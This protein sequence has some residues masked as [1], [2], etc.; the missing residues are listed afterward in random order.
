MR[1]DHRRTTLNSNRCP[2]SKELIMSKRIRKSFR[3]TVE[4]LETRLVPTQILVNTTQDLLGAPPGVVS[5]REAIRRANAHPG[6]DTILLPAGTYTLTQGQLSVTDSLT[7]VGRGVTSGATVIQGDPSALFRERLFDVLG[8][9][10]MSFANLTLQN[11]GTAFKKLGF[12]GGAVQA[13]SANIL[14]NNCVVSG[15]VGLKGGAINAEAGRVTLRNTTL[16]G[17]STIGNGGAV[18]AGPGGVVL[19]NDT[20]RDNHADGRGGAVFV[21]LGDVAV[22]HS[23]LNFNSAANGGAIDDGDGN[24][25]IRNGSL[26]HGNSTTGEGG[27]IFDLGTVTLVNSGV[28]DSHSGISGGG[29]SATRAVLT[30]SFVNDNRT[31]GFGG[32]ISAVD[33]ALAGSSF[34]TVNHA[35][36]GAGGGIFAVHT[37]TMTRSTVNTNTAQ[38][39][40]GIFATTANLTDST[41]SSNVASNFGGGIAAP[42]TTLV[43]STVSDNIATNAG[44]GID[45]ATLTMTDSTVS[46]NLV[47]TGLVSGIGGGIHAG[48]ATLNRSTVSGNHAATDGGGIYADKVHLTNATVSGNVAVRDGGGIF[49]TGKGADPLNSTILNSTIVFNQA[50]RLGGGVDAD[51]GAVNVKNTIIAL[52]TLVLTEFDFTDVFGLFLS[53]GHNLVTN[54]LSGNPNTSFTDPLNHDI[55]GVDPHIDH[56]LRN[57]GGLTLT[58]ALLA[59][60]PAIDQGDNLG[61]PAVDQRGVA[62]PRDGD[63]N[64]SKIVDI[65]AFEL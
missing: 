57:N 58:H 17:N 61:A 45:A 31:D 19:D 38:K 64:G 48:T 34:V 51:S 9:I 21:A 56:Q 55:L 30:G 62:R 1:A 24:V 10:N 33:V 12:D 25:S 4:G 43:R 47:V 37:V 60:S 11:G 23:S 65:G 50:E 6:P 18:C 52:N 59:G 26:L 41:V 54:Q 5:L 7:I 42:A 8:K 63:R 14:L 40:A 22:S 13:L 3:P 46:E 39:G 28:R 44:G 29:I 16:T 36:Q 49:L 2:G 53:Q 32:G 35:D 27:A 15:N 20:F